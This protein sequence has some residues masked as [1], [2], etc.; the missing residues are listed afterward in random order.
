MIE[1][2]FILDR[3]IGGPDVSF[4][5]EPEEFRA[6]S[7]AVRTAAV[8]LGQIHYGVSERN[9]DS[10]R[11]ARSLFAVRDIPQGHLITGEDIRSIRP[12]YGLHPKYL[13]QVIGMKARS[14]IER[15]TPISWNLA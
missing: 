4:S 1:K 10:R 13:P 15:G 12:S 14:Y 9:K 5:M 3:S 11:F 6:M 8:A 7:T 2:H